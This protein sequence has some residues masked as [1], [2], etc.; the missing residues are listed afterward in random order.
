MAVEAA[1]GRLPDPFFLDA[2]IVK[3]RDGRS[4]GNR[5]C[6]VALGVNL[7]GERDVL[8]IWFQASEGA[9]FWLAALNELKHAA[10]PTCSSSAP[11]GS[12]A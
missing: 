8:G 4:V 3:V 12:R 2:L 10:C 1:R 9:K 7:E 11:T 5:A 6:Y